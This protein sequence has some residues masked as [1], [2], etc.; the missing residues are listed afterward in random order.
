MHATIMPL[1]ANC[2][3]KREPHALYLN[4]NPTKIISFLKDK[5]SMNSGNTHTHTTKLQPCHGAGD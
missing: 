1:S 3:P 4:Q 5:S 2:S